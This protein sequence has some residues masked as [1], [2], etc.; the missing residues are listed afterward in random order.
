MTLIDTSFRTP[1]KTGVDSQGRL[2]STGIDDDFTESDLLILWKR[3]FLPT[4]SPEPG[5]PKVKISAVSEI[6]LKKAPIFQ[7]RTSAHST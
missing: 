7:G 5:W 6:Y 3:L 1:E 4:N 2:I